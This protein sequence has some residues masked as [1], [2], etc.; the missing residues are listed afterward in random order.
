MLR[1]IYMLITVTQNGR[2]VPFVPHSPQTP[3]PSPLLGGHDGGYQGDGG[4]RDGRAAERQ[5]AGTARDRVAGWQGRGVARLGVAGAG[6][7][8]APLRG[9]LLGESGQALPRV[10]ACHQ[11]V[12]RAGRV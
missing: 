10:L 11:V 8:V 4:R 5:G 2:W 3:P 7:A 12:E 6:L 9:A 1:G